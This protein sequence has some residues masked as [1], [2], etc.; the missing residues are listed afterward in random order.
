MASNAATVA[1]CHP[2]DWPPTRYCTNDRLRGTS[3][4]V[5]ICSAIQVTRSRSGRRRI[6]TVMMVAC[7]AKRAGTR[8]RSERSDSRS[9]S[10]DARDSTATMS[11]GHRRSRNAADVGLPLTAAAIDSRINPVPKTS[12]EFVLPLLASV[13]T[14]GEDRRGGRAGPAHMRTANVNDRTRTQLSQ[15]Y[16]NSHKNWP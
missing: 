4:M 16:G 11:H 14:T 9:V 8:T 6:P 5:A 12:V 1:V 15:C 10:S 2:W 3:R 7:T 13:D